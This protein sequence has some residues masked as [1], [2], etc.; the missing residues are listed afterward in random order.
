MAATA[1]GMDTRK[2]PRANL[3]CTVAAKTTDYTVTVADCKAGQVFT[4]TG[5]GGTVVFTL[6]AVASVGEC[7]LRFKVLA[8]QTIEILPATG[9]K[10]FL[11]CDGVASK[12]LAMPATAGVFAEILGDGTNWIVMFTN[13]LLTK[14]A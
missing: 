6:P 4:N 7:A 2:H 12:K 8:V 5:A 1:S 11:D 14:E 9:E 10:I 3:K 13:G